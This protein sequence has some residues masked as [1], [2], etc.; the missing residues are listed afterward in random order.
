[1]GSSY[2]TMGVTA[3]KP[4]LLL[5]A[6]GTD[7]T[8]KFSLVWSTKDIEVPEVSVRDLVKCVNKAI[9]DT[10]D[11]QLYRRLKSGPTKCLV[12]L[13]PIIF[14]F[15]IGLG[16][17]YVLTSYG[18]GGEWNFYAIFLPSIILG[19]ISAVGIFWLGDLVIRRNIKSQV[20]V[21]NGKEGNIQRAVYA[22]PHATIPAPF[23]SENI[24][25]RPASLKIYQRPL[26]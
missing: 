8:S 11:S 5:E 9:D 1:M 10:V 23:S 3:A 12:C 19:V 25:R 20:K 2:L 21:W 26:C 16:I 6:D 13:L 14:I 22:G 15:P 24:V 18:R 17:P 7:I 4:L